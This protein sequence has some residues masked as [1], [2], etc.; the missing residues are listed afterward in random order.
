MIR[1]LLLLLVVFN[2]IQALPINWKNRLK[3]E[4]DQVTEPGSSNLAQFDT[5]SK[6]NLEEDK[7]KVLPLK[8]NENKDLDIYFQEETAFSSLQSKK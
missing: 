6:F 1:Y 8:V 2:Y 5:L 3:N 7:F 4:L